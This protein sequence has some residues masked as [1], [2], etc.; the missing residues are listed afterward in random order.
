M[1]KKSG[2]S[3]EYLDRVIS[4][5]SGVADSTHLRLIQLVR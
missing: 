1:F 4:C 3:F 5:S 2:G